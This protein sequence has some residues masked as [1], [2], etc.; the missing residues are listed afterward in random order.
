MGILRLIAILYIGEALYYGYFKT[1]CN[2]V[3]W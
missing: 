2:F 3:Y 1:N